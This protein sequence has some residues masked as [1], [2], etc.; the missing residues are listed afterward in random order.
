MQDRN[1]A[2]WNLQSTYQTLPKVFYSEAT[3]TAVRQPQLLLVNTRVARRLGL[4]PNLIQDQLHAEIFSGNRLP[5]NSRPIAQAYAGHQ[6][7]GFT[8]LG[9]GRAILLG[10]QQTPSGQLL[11]VQLKGP[12]MTPYS[13]RGDGRAALGPMLREYIIAHAMDAL[14][15]PTTLSLAVTSTGEPV[16]RQ[17][18]EPGAVLTRIASSHVRVGTF[19]FAA[20]RGNVDDL[21]ALADYAIARHYSEL[22]DSPEKYLSFLHAVIERQAKLIARWMSVGFIHGVMN[23]DN[24][25]IAGET[26][27]YGP[28][29]FMNSYNPST[30]FSSID[31]GGRY[32]YGNQPAICQWNLARFAETLL[33]LLHSD[34]QQAVELATAAIHGFPEIY[35]AA[36][37]RLMSEKLGFAT[38]EPA[39]AQAQLLDQLLE[40]M[41]QHQLDFINT[42]RALSVLQFRQPEATDQAAATVNADHFTAT[43]SAINGTQRSDA[44]VELM[45]PW[46]QLWHAS[47]VSDGS[48]LEQAQARMLQL[49][50]SVIP[51]N[52]LV[53]QAIAAVVERGDFG[54]IQ[55]L[56]EVLSSPFELSQP[57]FE[58]SKPPAGGDG[59]YCTFCGT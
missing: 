47:L 55:S 34:Y 59:D 1:E 40:L 53:E 11:D 18:I 17:R 21:R 14:D 54:P 5:P 13:R 38:N 48:S 31:D 51:R 32:A 20:A 19:Q 41:E 29:A 46:L 26:I 37:R 24:V 50:P 52:H 36:W 44:I 10:E 27:D 8:M 12:G 42:M 15:I 49:N 45:N 28:C 2:G 56:L 22:V 35:E 33:P 25:S 4:D 16:Y 30:V 3:P 57:N 7:G 23:T 9:D 39:P 6:F 43:Y 58:Y